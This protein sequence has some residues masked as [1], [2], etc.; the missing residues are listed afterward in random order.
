MNEIAKVTHKTYEI[1]FDITSEE[2]KCGQLALSDKSLAKLKTAIDRAGKKRRQVNVAAIH[3][4][5]YFH[6]DRTEIKNC[7]IVLLR[8][9]DRKA[10]VKYPRESG[11]SQVDICELYPPAARPKLETYVAAKKAAQ[12][13]EDDAR[14]LQEKLEPLDAAAIRELV[15]RQE[16]EKV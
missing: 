1:V 16:E 15:V 11:Q 10:D 2:W 7:T 13:A 6:N 3:L 8:D 9:G 14:K 12:K 4:Q 5:D